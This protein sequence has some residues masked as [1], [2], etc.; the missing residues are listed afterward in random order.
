MRPFSMLGDGILADDSLGH[1]EAFS[2][3][4]RSAA[5]LLE[6]R[7]KPGS[8]GLDPIAYRAAAMAALASP[9]DIT[10]ADAT[11]FFRT[12]FTVLNLRPESES[13][14]KRGFVTGYYEPEVEAAAAPTNEYRTPLYRKP[15]DLVKVDSVN[16]PPGM[17]ESFRF[18]RRLPSGLL[19]E[20]A[21]RPAIERGALR[22]HGLEIAWLKSPVDAFFIHVQG[23]ARLRMTDGTVKR[24]GYAAKTGHPFT[25]IGKVLVDSGELSLAEADMAGIRGWLERHPDRLRWLFDHN[26]SFIFFAEH[27][28]IDERLGP[29]GAAKVPLTPLAS[30]AVDRERATYG[31]PYLIDAPDLAIDGTPY[32]R[33]AVAQDTGSAIIGN[34]R[35]DIFLGSG[36]AAG[37]IAGRVRHAADF[38]V[39]VPRS[40]AAKLIQ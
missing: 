2:A 23:S 39:L 18:A 6:G 32:R 17:D 38:A 37:D 7:Y 30:I 33:I 11:A 27:S 12:H 24:V 5:E 28:L 20:Y 35:A 15:A 4:R 16:R 40:L 36:D 34:A 10:N 26:R 14:R 3:F 8:L 31:V 25:A 21:D 9:N 29:V 22:G 1:T 19:E 13:P